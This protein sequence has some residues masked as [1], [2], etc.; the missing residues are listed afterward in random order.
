MALIVRYNSAMATIQVRN[1]PDE[2]AEIYRRRA[3]ASG[4]SLQAYMRDQLIAGAQR[5]D[6]AEVMAIMRETL[7]RDPG[8]GLTAETLEASLRELRGE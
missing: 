7:A 8:P 5:R 1:L 6:K 4:Q 3:E 2:I